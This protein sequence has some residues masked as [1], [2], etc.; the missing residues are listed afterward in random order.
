MY[1]FYFT[2]ASINTHYIA[3]S[4]SFN[5][6]AYAFSSNDAMQSVHLNFLSRLL[7]LP[8][9]EKYMHTSTCILCNR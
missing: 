5:G 9:E 2:I 6:I 4:S 3:N 7:G 8:N 1:I